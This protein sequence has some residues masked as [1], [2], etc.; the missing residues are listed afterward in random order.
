MK[1]GIIVEGG[2]MRGIY[3]SGVLDR[4]LELGI[5][6]DYG[7]GASAGGAN[8][9]T[10]QAHQLKRNY[11]F[12]H[13]YSQDATTHGKDPID[14][15]R[16]MQDPAELEVVATRCDTGEAVYFSKHQMSLNHYDAIKASCAIP[17]ACRPVFIDGVPYSDGGVSDPLPIAR[18]LSKG[19]SFLV[20][21][22]VHHW[23]HEVKPRKENSFYR[24]ALKEYP[25]ILSG[26]MKCD[27]IHEEEVQL[28]FRLKEQNRAMIL[29]PDHDEDL[30]SATR[31]QKI[32]QKYY[33]LGVQ[34]AD[35]IAE[36][37]LARMAE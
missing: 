7:A 35:Q 19:C 13:D 6:F 31:N 28:A 27:T 34:D 8:L 1:T 17:I 18:A 4:F 20:I 32:L 29:M 11:R 22:L 10:F 24:H 21:V 36:E 23:P 25:A 26:I 30:G 33:D 16:M 9:V 37:L 14:F 5:H 15:P 3:S 2:G 12:Y